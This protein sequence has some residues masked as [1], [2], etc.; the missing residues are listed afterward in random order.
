[1]SEVTI[2]AVDDQSGPRELL[3]QILTG[4]GYRVTTANDGVEALRILENEP[5]DLVVS[6]RVSDAHA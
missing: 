3:R 4:A 5:H 6:D 2:L 1:M